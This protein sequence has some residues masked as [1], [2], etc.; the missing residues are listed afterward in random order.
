MR[1]WWSSLSEYDR[2]AFVGI[3]TIVVCTVVFWLAYGVL[4]Y[5]H[6]PQR[7]HF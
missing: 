6:N 3:S 1:K 2:S 5:V 7:W 4:D